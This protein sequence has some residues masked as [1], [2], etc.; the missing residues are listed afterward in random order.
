VTGFPDH[1]SA[2]ASTYATYR[3]GYPAQLFDWLAAVAPR[4]QMVWDCACGSG[5]ASQPLASRFDRVVATDASPAQIASAAQQGNIRFVVA[6]AERAPLADDAADLVTIAQAL[7]W[8]ADSAFYSEV[9]R[10]VR[11]AGVI[12][13]WT[14][15]LPNVRTEAINR[16]L[17][18]FINDDLGQ[19]WP[20]EVR[21]VL[22]GYATI[23]FPFEEIDVP[24]FEI[25]E[26]WTLARF[27]GFVRTWSGVGRFIDVHGKDPVA[28]LADELEP[29][30]RS[31]DATLTITWQLKARVGRVTRNC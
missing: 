22:D 2:V 5:Q 3:P 4:G 20:P 18:R 6:R 23:E 19:Y 1:F 12:A 8:F 9:R 7:H 25:N 14:Y 10:V 26:R 17:L 21:H 28:P 15:G 27:L 30:W 13:A 24:H 31:P 29:L 11:P 16:L